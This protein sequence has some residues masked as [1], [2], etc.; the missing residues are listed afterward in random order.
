[1]RKKIHGRNREY[2]FTMWD[3]KIIISLNHGNDYPR[4]FS[5]GFCWLYLDFAIWCDTS[6][7]TSQRSVNFGALFRPPLGNS[8]KSFR[9]I[10]RFSEKCWGCH[11]S[12]FSLFG[13]YIGTEVMNK[14]LNQIFKFQRIFQINF[15]ISQ[16]Y[17]GFQ[18]SKDFPNKFSNFPNI[19]WDIF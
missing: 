10:H 11:N 8:G 3:F 9:W 18:I 12:V 2:N 19:F 7:T 6:T 13:T 16:K 4:T 15:Q 5:P 17:F 14:S 1:M